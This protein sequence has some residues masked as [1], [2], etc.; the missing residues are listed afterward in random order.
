MLASSG[1][2]TFSA[3]SSALKKHG[4][5][6]IS[7]A[8][9]GDEALDMLS[10]KAHD[11]VIADEEFSDMTGLEFVKKLVV[12]NPM[13]NSAI[14]SRLSAEEFH[15]VGEGLGLLMQLPPLPGEVEA[16]NLMRCLK[17][18]SGLTTTQNE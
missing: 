16:E 6:N 12:V 1:E 15:E 9:S 2:N 8:E 17:K 5:V 18:I 13:V 11:L 10:G 3:L 4:D 7:R 14:V